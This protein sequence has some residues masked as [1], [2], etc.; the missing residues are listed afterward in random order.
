MLHQR[1]RLV[2]QLL[3]TARSAPEPAHDP[4][5]TACIQLNDNG[6]ACAACKAWQ[7]HWQL[8]SAAV[9]QITKHA[10]LTVRISQT[11]AAGLILVCASFSRNPGQDNL[12]RRLR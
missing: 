5:Q 9:D 1:T 2:D 7:Q 6:S 10:T 3:L 12:C 11:T 4:V 8:G